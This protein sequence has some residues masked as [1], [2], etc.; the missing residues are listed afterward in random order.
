MQPRPSVFSLAGASAVSRPTT[1]QSR[2]QGGSKSQPGSDPWAAANGRI[3][4]DDE[5][6]ETQVSLNL[7]LNLSLILKAPLMRL[8]AQ[9]WLGKQVCYGA[10]TVML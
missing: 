8:M 9:F 4:L 7:N 6:E 3:A 5:D 10:S 1:A 2:T